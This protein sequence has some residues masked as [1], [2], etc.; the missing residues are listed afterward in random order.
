MGAGGSG[1]R[2]AVVR[3][4]FQTR[5]WPLPVIGLVVAVLLG[6]AVPLLDEALDD[7]MPTVLR[8]VLFSGGPD[9]AR[10]VL[11]A[12]AGS[13]ITVTSLTFSLTVVTLQLASSQ[14]S[15]R[16]LRTFSRD[17]F[18]HAVLAVF[19]GTF[20]YTLVVMRTIRN[21]GDAG[22]LFV[23]ELG[24]TLTVLATL[25]AVV[26]IVLF[27]AHLS[28]QIRVEMILE[29]V[30]KET[31][32]TIDRSLDRRGSAPDSPP[33]PP[34]P[35]HDAALLIAPRTGV[36]ASADEDA[37]LQAAAD[38]SA[39]VLVEA[40]P[41][42]SVVAGTPVGRCWASRGDPPTGE[43]LDRLRTR[44]LAALQIGPERTAAQ[45][46]A[47]GLRQLADVADK[48]L[49]PG[50]N[51]PT[52]AVHA[53]GHLSGALCHAL[54]HELGPRLLR[55]EHD[56]VRVVLRRPGFHDL[57]DDAIAQPRRFGADS[58]DVLGR[59]ARLLQEVAWCVPDADAAASVRQQVVRTRQTVRDA[60]LPAT[61]DAELERE[62]ARVEQVLEGRW[63]A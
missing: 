28:S 25:A 18:V 49:S 6:V 58:P 20:A 8:T 7:R 15:P 37:L 54:R 48:A 38:A 22:G 23:P 34:R 2:R 3:E 44:V 26:C 31:E 33:A 45:D 50:I 41:G 10:T 11:S 32:T 39:V 24:V 36:L 60:G 17:R 53:L 12:V 56:A 46:V 59:I 9:A 5:L 40:Q 35:P 19:L 52:T 27:L 51:D 14:F 16:L 29:R 63:P 62:L 57:L 21:D 30:R 61:E 4:G 43:A 47:F 1:G 13:L 42:D 55:D